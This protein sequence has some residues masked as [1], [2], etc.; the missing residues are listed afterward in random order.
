MSTKTTMQLLNEVSG[1]ID[2]AITNCLS[3]KKRSTIK[4]ELSLL[5]QSVSGAIDHL[6]EHEKR[7][8]TGVKKT[9]KAVFNVVDGSLEGLASDDM[10]RPMF[11]GIMN[12]MRTRFYPALCTSISS[13][14][15]KESEAK[16]KE[17]SQDQEVLVEQIS[18]SAEMADV[19]KVIRK[20]VKD[21]K[22]DVAPG[23]SGENATE[24]QLAD[25]ASTRSNLPLRLKTGF[26]AIRMPIVP[27]F[28]NYQMN[29][30]STFA[31][32]GIKHVLVEG[33]AVLLDQQLIAISEKAAA[34]IDMTPLQYAESVVEVINA[35][36][37][38]EYEFVSDKPIS[39]PRNAD[40]QMFWILPKPKMG[41]LMRVAL[42]GRKA[43]TVKWG[44]PF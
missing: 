14:V 40:V 8:F 6:N 41:A 32:I 16:V 5:K 35:R 44:F 2:K 34:K 13:E 38:V 36:S 30:P 42:T 23:Q 25:L 1:Q 28:S 22:S 18:Q 7:K 4:T 31:K 17:L 11:K 24:K 43:S 3:A 26:Q 9:L 12:N 27:I 21:G 37:S 15:E 20:S 33:Y 10:T 39:N 19:L 29:N